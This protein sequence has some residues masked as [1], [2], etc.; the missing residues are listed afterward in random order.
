MLALG[1]G[2]D[3]SAARSATSASS[4]VFGRVTDFVPLGV[5]VPRL[6]RGRPPTS[7]SPTG[8][9]VLWVGRRAIPSSACTTSGSSPAWTSTPAASSRARASSTSATPAIRSSS[10]RSTTPR[11]PTSSSSSTSPRPPTS[12]TRSSS[13]RAAPPTRCSSRS[14]SAA[15]SARS[16]TRRPCSTPGADKVS[17]NS[18]A[19]ARPE[20]IDELADVFGAQCVVLAIDAK[21]AGRRLGGLRRRRPHADRARRGRVGARG[22]RA[23]GGGDPAHLDGPR[24]HQGR[25]RPRPAA[26][27]RERRRRAGDRLRRRRR[28]RAPRRRASAPART[29][30]CSPRSS[31]TASTRSPRSS[32]TSPRPGVGVAGQH[33]GVSC[34]S[35][36]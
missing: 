3:R 33:F 24:R 22:R 31:T 35:D 5:P 17:V 30:S 27:D 12:A 1:A 32:A 4:L 23:R 15:A 10:P 19:V 6:R 8:L 36:E 21:R 28:A 20:L 26:R 18:A 11:A 25:L 14:R 16:P 29:R 34:V 9:V 13:S 7:S 2:V